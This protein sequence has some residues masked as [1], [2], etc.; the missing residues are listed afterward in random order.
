[1]AKIH[2]PL[3]RCKDLTL[4]SC[5]MEGTD[6]SFAYPDAE[7]DVKGHIHSV[8]NPRSGVISAASVR[9]ITLEDAIMEC[10]GKVII[11]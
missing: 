2:P 3:C 6:L 10:T 7:A 4:I 5:T 8:K 9:E 11:R 1:M